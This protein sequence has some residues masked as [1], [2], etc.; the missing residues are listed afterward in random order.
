[1]AE[2][3]GINY[4]QLYSCWQVISDF[5]CRLDFTAAEKESFFYQVPV[6]LFICCPSV[7]LSVL[8]SWHVKFVDFFLVILV[9]LVS[10][11]RIWVWPYIW[12]VYKKKFNYC[13]QLITNLH[14]STIT[15]VFVKNLFCWLFWFGT[16]T[17]EI[18]LL[19]VQT[20]LLNNLKFTLFKRAYKAMHLFFHLIRSHCLPIY[21]PFIIPKPYTLLL[22]TLSLICVL[23]NCIRFV[24]FS[25][26]SPTIFC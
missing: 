7:S 19:L 10:K 25:S 13:V 14:R 23:L 11:C 20:E 4:K 16:I 5:F 24:Y 3:E 15:F 8:L 12:N 17:F 21:P 6:S 2:V 26:F 18:L 22:S 9:F 1:M